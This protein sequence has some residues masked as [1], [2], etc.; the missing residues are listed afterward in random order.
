MFGLY[1]EKQV[2]KLVDRLKAEYEEE[3]VKMRAEFE[4]LKAENGSLRAQN[5]ALEA[6]RTNVADALIA[7]AEMKARAKESGRAE[8]DNC[9]R[10]L[11]LLAEKCRTL[12]ENLTRRYPDAE[13]IASFNAFVEEL[14]KELGEEIEEEPTGFNMDDVIAPK[15]PLDLG[16]LCK[17]LGLME[18]DE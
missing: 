4:S 2:K 3:F 15:E 8:A 16:K 10:E 13:D 11:K 14:R 6:E 1:T 9:G 17:D 5:L 12:A 18:E 7:A